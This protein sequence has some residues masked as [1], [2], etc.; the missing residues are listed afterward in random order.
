MHIKKIKGGKFAPPANVH[1]RD[2]SIFMKIRDGKCAIAC[3]KIYSDPVDIKEYQRAKICAVIGAGECE[4][5]K[6]YLFLE[7]Q[8]RKLSVHDVTQADRS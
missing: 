5:L 1:T 3:A 7:Y 2:C 8:V 6:N 4:I